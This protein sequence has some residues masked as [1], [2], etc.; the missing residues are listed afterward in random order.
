MT[1]LQLFTFDGNDDRAKGTHNSGPIDEVQQFTFAGTAHV[2][3]VTSDGGTWFVAKDVCDVLEIRDARSSL[4]FLDEDEKGVHTVHTP[5]GPQRVTV[6]NEPGLYSLVLRSRKPDAKRFKRWVTHEVLPTIRQTGG[7]YIAPGS[8]AAHA[9][10]ANPLDAIEQTLKV[11]RDLE[12]KNRELQAAVTAAAPKVE[13][14]DRFM[15]AEGDYAM[16]DVARMLGV[17]RTTLFARMR[18]DGILIDG[19]AGHNT[20]YQRYMRHFRVV[21]SEYTDS[22]GKEH[23]TRTTY[24]RPSGVEF[25]ARRLGL[26]L[27]NPNGGAA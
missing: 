6:V 15:T 18:A 10:L 12:S 3:V 17:G 16:G 13:A 25:I 5:G 7:A 11:A 4:R 26:N 1:N 9:M 21:A 27:G 2:R 22:K 8:A 20:P 14:Y 23:A 19:G 24:V